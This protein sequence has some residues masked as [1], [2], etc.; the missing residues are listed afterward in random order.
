MVHDRGS[1]FHR[2]PLDQNLSKLIFALKIVKKA[3]LGDVGCGA[4]LID[5]RSYKAFLQHEILGC[6]EQGF[7]RI[8]LLKG[9]H[10]D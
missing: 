7:L 3:A 10:T 9:F 1:H 2:E 5:A 6:I 8:G 4:D